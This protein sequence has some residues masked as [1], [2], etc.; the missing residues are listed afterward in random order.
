MLKEKIDI[1]DDIRAANTRKIPTSEKN[2]SLFLVFLSVDN[3]FFI[4]KVLII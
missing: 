3:K 1:P 4:K 2:L